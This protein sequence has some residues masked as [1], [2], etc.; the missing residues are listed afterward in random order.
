M[1]DVRI[2]EIESQI[3]V[4]DVDALLTPEVIDMVVNAVRQKLSEEN[5]VQQDADE[6]R[7]LTEG[8]SS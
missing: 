8:V 3:S 6:D 2:N 5:R 7:R 4:A 1:A